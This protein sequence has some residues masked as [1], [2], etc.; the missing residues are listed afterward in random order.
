MKDDL[1]LRL[2]KCMTELNKLLDLTNRS[3][4]WGK[5]YIRQASFLNYSKPKN[6]EAV[7]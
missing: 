5:I 7:T 6:Q 2:V 1:L 3:G 4:Q